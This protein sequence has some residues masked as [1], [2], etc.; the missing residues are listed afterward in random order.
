MDRELAAAR[1]IPLVR[2]FEANKYMS[3]MNTVKIKTG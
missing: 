2:K 1:I 3:N